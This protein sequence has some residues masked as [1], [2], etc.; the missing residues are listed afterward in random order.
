MEK[1]RLTANV[2]I[3]VYTEVEAETI[4]EAKAIAEERELC[5][6]TNTGGDTE[7]DVW[8][9]NELDGMPLDIDKC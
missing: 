9:C 7:D 5:S 1:F 2:T 6:I 3:S 8:M 4:E